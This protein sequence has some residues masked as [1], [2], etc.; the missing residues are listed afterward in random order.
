MPRLF[1][2][3]TKFGEPK[4]NN[5]AWITIYFFFRHALLD[6]IKDLT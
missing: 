6:R 1:S 5:Q 2:W 3:V 4:L